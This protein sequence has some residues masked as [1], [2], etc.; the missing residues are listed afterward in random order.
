MFCDLQQLI[1]GREGLPYPKQTHILEVPVMKTFNKTY[2]ASLFLGAFLIHFTACNLTD[3]GDNLSNPNSPTEQETLPIKP[4]DPEPEFIPIEP[5]KP[6]PVFYPVTPVEPKPVPLPVKPTEPG[7][8]PNPIHHE[9][10]PLP[11]EW[12]N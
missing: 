8:I 5:V 10:K 11:V 4:I 12:F 7:P 9:P 1:G 2:A 3:S 6:D